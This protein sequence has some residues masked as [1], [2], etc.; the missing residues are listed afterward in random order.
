MQYP[1]VHI[2]VAAT[3][4]RISIGKRGEDPAGRRL[5]RKLVGIHAEI[6]LH[7]THVSTVEIGLIDYSSEFHEFG[8][9]EQ[10]QKERIVPSEVS[11][12]AYPRVL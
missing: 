10:R 3:Q 1:I 5:T 4:R 8:G 6:L 12:F 11:K 9:C 2:V 7:S